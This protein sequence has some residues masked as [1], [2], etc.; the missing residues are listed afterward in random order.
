MKMFNVYDPSNYKVGKHLP[1]NRL[2]FFNNDI[3]LK[4]LNLSLESY[5]VNVRIYFWNDFYGGLN[6]IRVK[7]VVNLH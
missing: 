1:A 6:L 5:K 3:D 7:R 4:W 2:I